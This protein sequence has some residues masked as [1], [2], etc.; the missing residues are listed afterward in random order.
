VDPS[1][2][3]AK[4]YHGWPVTVSQFDNYDR[5]AAAYLPTIEVTGRD[6]PVVQVIDEASGEIV[7]TVRIK[8]NTF[9]PRVFAPGTY[10]V[11]VDDKVL[12]GV[13]SVDAD[14][15]EVLAVTFE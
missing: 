7:Y 11:K 12:K 4:C 10:T 3:G 9:K 5:K 15:T 8:G 1:K 13:R 14:S 2:P 6:D